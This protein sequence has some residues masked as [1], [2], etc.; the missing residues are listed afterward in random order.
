LATWN[1]DFGSEALSKHEYT[2]GGHL[3]AEDLSKFYISPLQNPDPETMVASLNQ[4]RE[5]NG[6]AVLELPDALETGP[7]QLTL[8]S[9]SGNYLLLLGQM[10]EDGEYEVRTLHVGD[11]KGLRTILGDPF[12]EFAITDDFQIVVQVFTEL[13]KAGDISKD[14]MW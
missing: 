7:Q 3:I 14:L 12:P 8:Y 1:E 10:E 13:L 2:Y 5:H 11:G 9:D 6:I 4:F